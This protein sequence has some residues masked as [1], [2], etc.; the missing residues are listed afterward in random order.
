MKIY[1]I[2]D[3]VNTAHNDE[4]YVINC[5]VLDNELIMNMRLML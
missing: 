3:N 2:D 5:F 4:A 1:K